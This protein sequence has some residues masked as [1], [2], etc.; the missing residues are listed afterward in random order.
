M[1][2][3]TLFKIIATII[4]ILV[5]SSILLLRGTY[6]PLKSFF[7]K[8]GVVSE[9]TSE[10]PLPSVGGKAGSIVGAVP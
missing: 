7:S 4:I 3:K 9:T 8:M 2:R 10:Q 1:K 5:V 6:I